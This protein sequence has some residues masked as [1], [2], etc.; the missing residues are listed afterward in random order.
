MHSSQVISIKLCMFYFQAPIKGGYKLYIEP[1]PSSSSKVAL[2]FQ[3][4]GNRAYVKPMPTEANPRKRILVAT[5]ND[6][7]IQYIFVVTALVESTNPVC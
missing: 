1:D 4:N 7:D 5:E 6:D 3:V 2:Y